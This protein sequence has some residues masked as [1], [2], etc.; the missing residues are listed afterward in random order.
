MRTEHPVFGVD[1]RIS[2]NDGSLEL[3]GAKRFETRDWKMV[4]R[5]D[6]GAVASRAPGL[7]VHG[8]E[9]VMVLLAVRLEPEVGTRP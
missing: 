2:D 4:A 8:R 5:L 9:I 3:V 7:P 6:R 1:F